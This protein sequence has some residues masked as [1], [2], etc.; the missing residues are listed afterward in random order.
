MAKKLTL[1]PDRVE[2]Y[3]NQYC[4]IDGLFTAE[5]LKSI[6]EYFASFGVENSYVVGSDGKPIENTHVR[7]SGIKMH[8]VND[9]NLWIFTRLLQATEHAND[10][11]FNFDLSGFDYFQ[12]TEYD[13]EGSNYDWHIDT[14]LG[15]ELPRN[16]HLMRKISGSLILSDPSE[17]KGG[18]FEIMVGGQSAESVAQKQGSIIFF[19]SFIM[20]RVAPLIEGKRKSL[21]FW[22]MGPKFK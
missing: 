15:E 12:Y 17:Y 13:G 8:K 19:P 1:N 11:F 14:V 22:V 5:E 10:N 9:K 16:M 7:L 18:N 4:I 21:V 6:N 2:K 20:H 3:L